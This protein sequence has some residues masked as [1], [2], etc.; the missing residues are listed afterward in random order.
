MSGRDA[1]KG[2]CQAHWE[3]ITWTDKDEHICAKN[4]DG[5]IVDLMIRA[6]YVGIDLMEEIWIWPL[7]FLDWVI[8]RVMYCN[9]SGRLYSRSTDLPFFEILWTQ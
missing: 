5:F 6:T 2:S 9:G 4:N 7:G 8:S 3:R 1:R